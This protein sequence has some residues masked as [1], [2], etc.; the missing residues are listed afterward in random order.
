MQVPIIAVIDIFPALLHGTWITIQV[1][2]GAIALACAAS[3]AAA[4]CRLSGNPAL[5]WP[6]RIYI[7]FF[8]G[9]SALVQ[10]FWA[11]YVLPFSGINIGPLTSAIIV[12]GLNGGAYGS[13]I[14]RGAVSAIPQ[15]QRDAAT[16]LNLPRFSRIFGIMTPQALPLI[17]PPLTNLFIDILKNS[18]LAGLVTVGDLTFQAQVLREST[19]ASGYIF[20]VVMLIYFALAICMS[21]A[22]RWLESRVNFP[23]GGRL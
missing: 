4:L 15:G 8:R 2:L 11:F 21:M 22:M 1:T 13:E 20:G 3:T 23:R 9:T 19:P 17:L 14:I 6:A 16:A 7:E 10:L 18:A 5:S 12:L